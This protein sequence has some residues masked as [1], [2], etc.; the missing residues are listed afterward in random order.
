[1][2]RIPH[3]YGCGVGQQLQLRFDPSLST[4]VCRRVALESKKKKAFVLSP[5][6]TTNL[7]FYFLISFPSGSVGALVLPYVGASRGVALLSIPK[8]LQGGT[9]RRE[10]TRTLSKPV[11]G[12]PCPR[13][14][15]RRVGGHPGD[16]MGKRSSQATAGDQRGGRHGSDGPK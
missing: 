15:D 12:G 5:V 11:R 6:G 7:V 9:C 1:M 14:E 10:N 13:E 3:S 2:A 16:W 8:T 4:S